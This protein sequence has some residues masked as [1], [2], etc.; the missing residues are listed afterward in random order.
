M[1]SSSS[2]SSS[3]GVALAAALIL[4]CAV[5]GGYA[6]IV[7][8]IRHGFIDALRTCTFPT[9]FPPSSSSSSSSSSFFFFITESLSSSSS[10]K[11]KCILDLP[12]AFALPSYTGIG[13]IDARIAVL[14]EFFSQGLV[15]KPGTDGADWEALATVGYLSA[16]FGGAWAL[17][18]M[19]GL[20]RGNGNSVLRW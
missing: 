11:S 3:V 13:A 9:Y 14:L 10:S 4:S 7:T 18:V 20:R 17:M 16:Q 15:R 12:Y 1:S 19:E 8:S 2:S 5:L 6:S